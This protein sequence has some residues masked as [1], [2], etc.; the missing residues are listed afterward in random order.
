ME[1]H[2]TA[3]GFL[4]TGWLLLRKYFSAHKYKKILFTFAT[5]NV[6]IFQIYYQPFQQAH[7]DEAFIPY[8]NHALTDQYFENSVMVRLVEKNMHVLC[9]YFGVLSWNTKVK[10]PLFFKGEVMNGTQLIEMIDGGTYAD[11]IVFNYD[12]ANKN[13]YYQTLESEKYLAELA[14]KLFME[15]GHFSVR[16]VFCNAAIYRN[17]FVARP[18]IYEAYVKTFLQP[19][20]EVTSHCMELWKDSGYKIL[21]QAEKDYFQLQFGRSYYPRHAFFC[22]RLFCM[23]LVLC[24]K[25]FNVK[26]L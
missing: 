18:E 23:W 13:P 12:A 25:N 11:V 19:M 6:R 22:E 10:E 24:G 2:V 15:F 1:I 20:I 8:N 7:L 21:N 16:N 9:D 5:V 26:Y 3:F 14:D 17:S 4:L